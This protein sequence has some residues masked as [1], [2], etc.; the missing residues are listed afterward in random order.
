MIEPARSPVEGL[1]VLNQRYRVL[2][3][4][5]QGSIARVFAARDE[6]RG[7]DVAVKLLH[8]NLRRDRIVAARFTREAEIVRRIDH[9]HVIRIDDIVAT[10]EQLFLVMELH[11]GGDLADRLARTGPLPPAELRRLAEQ[12]CG[13]LE[14]AHRAGVVH[15]DIKPQ[16]VLVGP[17]PGALDV[18]LCDFGLAR[19]ADSAGLT[20]RTTVLGTPEYMAPEVIVDGYADPRSDLYSLGALLFEAATGRLPFR[21]DTPFQLMRRQVEEPAPRPRELDPGLPPAIDAAIARAL[22]KEPLDRFATA[23]ELASAMGAEGS[24]ALENPAALALL[25]RP[26]RLASGTCPRCGGSLF[27]VAQVCVDCGAASLAVRRRAGGAAVL[28][29]G[30]G[31]TGHKLGGRAHVAL[32][33]LLDELPPGTARLDRLR[34]KPPRL[35]FYLLRDLEDESAAQLVS[36]LCE[37]GVEARVERRASLA[38]REM[39]KKILWL[40]RAYGLA[41]FG[42]SFGVLQP[43]VFTHRHLGGAEFGLRFV[44]TLLAGPVAAL[45]YVLATERRP[46]AALAPLTAGDR[47][48]A[49][50]ARRLPELGRREDRRLLARLLDRLEVAVELGA[51]DVARVL[52]ARAALACRAL[53]ALDQARQGVDEDDLRRSA[54]RE[55]EGGNAQAALGRLRDGERQRGAVIADLLRVLSRLDLVCLRLARAGALGAGREIDALSR[56]VAD[57]QVELEAERDVAALLDRQKE[58]AG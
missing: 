27:R 21:A 18:R 50:L 56:E 40:W 51:S 25:P 33:K 28:V 26:S 34:K 47:P 7:V 15:R 58:G 14:A 4:L 39:A 29:I 57:L 9:Q 3:A 55:R 48:I 24:E 46:L 16:N 41:A 8:A 6:A 52:G 22:S 23:A 43:L 31:K 12:L 13:A 44:G 37:A 11:P 20:T 45:A 35:P 17:D 32:I 2:R 53:V 36:R 49:D 5:G 54:A 19:V 38:T 10:D 30:P 42:M 1:P